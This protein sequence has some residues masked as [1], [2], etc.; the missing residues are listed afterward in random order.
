M[1]PSELQA[2][3]FVAAVRRRGFDV[4]MLLV[5]THLGYWQARTVFE[6][7]REDVVAPARARGV[8]QIWLAGISLGGYGALLYDARY[9]GEIAGVVTLA[10]YLGSDEVVNEVA[11]AGGLRGWTPPTLAPFA[12]APPAE[13]A[14]QHLWRWLKHNTLAGT[15]G[16]P[17]G[18]RLP[19]FLSFGDSDRFVEAHRLVAEVL[20]AGQVAVASGGHD[21]PAW[22]AGWNRLLDQVPWPRRPACVS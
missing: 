13:V 15:P 1:A 19:L 16:S 20:P 10:P 17:H 9:P 8:Q 3:G 12:G 2:R 11:R 18:P 22:Q 14:D 6:V 4:D 7:L 21:W 5:D